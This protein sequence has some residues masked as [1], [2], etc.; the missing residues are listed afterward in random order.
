[1]E[2]VRCANFQF[3]QRRVRDLQAE[4]ERLRRQLD[5][6]LPAGKRQAGPFAKPSEFQSP[7]MGSRPTVPSAPP[8]T[9]GPHG[10]RRKSLPWAQVSGGPPSRTWHTCPVGHIDPTLWD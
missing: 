3:L 9:A 7:V 4:N 2:A 5:A 6:A 10:L 1:M 8:L